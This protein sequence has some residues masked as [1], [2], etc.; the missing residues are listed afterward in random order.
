[1]P[2]IERK[3]LLAELG[4][5]ACALM[6]PRYER[7]VP[8]APKQGKAPAGTTSMNSGSQS[9]Q[10][11]GSIP[12]PLSGI[13]VPSFGFR[14]RLR[15]A[16]SGMGS[17]CG[18]D[19]HLPGS[20][21]LSA[22]NRLFGLAV[23]AQMWLLFSTMLSSILSRFPGFLQCLAARTNSSTRVRATSAQSRECDK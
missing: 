15:A 2:V 1:M 8:T 3:D 16:A 4:K 18:A 5:L 14:L 11:G 7:Y 13:Q 9:V 22:S 21:R 12:D 6:P 19:S 10:G 23:S 17:I 20:S